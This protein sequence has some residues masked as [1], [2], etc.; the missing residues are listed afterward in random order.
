MAVKKTLA[1]EVRAV[2]APDGKPGVLL[3]FEQGWMVVTPANARRISALLLDVADE[4]EGQL[5]SRTEGPPR[6]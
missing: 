1:V 3:Q 2:T 5:V 4:V 6:F